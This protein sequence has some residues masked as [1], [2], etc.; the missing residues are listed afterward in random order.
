MVDALPGGLP[1]LL[2]FTS[3]P[4]SSAYSGLSSFDFLDFADLRAVDAFAFG[5]FALGVFF[6]ADLLP[7]LLGD[8]SSSSCAES[9]CCALT[10]AS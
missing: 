2:G 9:S 8:C 10:L 5:V 3:L 4:L 7:F 6:A 1:L